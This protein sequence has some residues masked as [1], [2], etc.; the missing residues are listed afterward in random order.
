MPSKLLKASQCSRR[1]E[2]QKQLY[3]CLRSSF[4]GKFKRPTSSSTST[5]STWDFDSREEP[6]SR[7]S[8]SRDVHVSRPS[9][10]WR[11]KP[12]IGPQESSSS[13]EVETGRRK[14]LAQD[15]AE[16]SESERSS[17]SEAEDEQKEERIVIPAKKITET[18]LN[19]IGAKIVKAEIM[20]NEVSKC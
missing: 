5:S 11:K 16:V 8:L 18:D 9:G 19:E 13:A 4:A 1:P 17:C 15:G 12:D 7:A 20:G 6:K 3:L 2:R 10:G 14:E